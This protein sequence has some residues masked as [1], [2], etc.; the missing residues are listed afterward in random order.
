MSLSIGDRLGHD[1]VRTLIG[2]GGRPAARGEGPAATLSSARRLVAASMVLLCWTPSASLAQELAPGARYDPAIP[3][4]EATVGHDHGDEITTPEQVAR[5]LDALAAAAPNRLTVVEYARSWEGRPLYL[6]VIASSERIARLDELTADLR[7][8]SDPGALAAD[9]VERLVATLPVVTWLLHGVHGNEISSTDAALA[10]LYHLLASRDDETVDTILRESVVLIDPMQNPDGRARFIYQHLLGR[11][12]TPDPEPV[13]A[14][15]DE[16]WPGGRTNHYLF[17]MNRDWFGQT[18]PETRGRVG[19]YLEWFA[20]VVVDL[21]EMGGNSTYFFAP[22]T[23]PLNP[24]LSPSQGDWLDQ[25]GRQNAARFDSRGFPY[26]V[27]ESYDLF[28]PGYGDSWPSLHGAIGMTYEQAS[29]RGLVFRRTDDMQLSYRDGVVHH[30]TAALATAE[31]AA[32]NREALLRD[33]VA[34][35]RGSQDDEVVEYLLPP[36]NDV[37]RSDQLARVLTAQGIQVR[38]TLAPIDIDD[39]QLPAGTYIVPLAQGAGRLART[40]LDPVTAMDD[41]FVEEQDRRRRRRQ[42]DQIYDITGWSLPLVYDVEAIASDRVTEVETESVA[43]AWLGPQDARV[44]NRER[45]RTPVAPLA[46]AT[47]A[48]LMPW[49]LATAATVTEALAAGLRV[50]F[51]NKAFTLGGR[52]FPPG[53]AIVR[54]AEHGATLA[55]TLGGIVARHGAEVVGTDTGWVEDGISLGSNQVVALKTPRV[56]L[57]WDEPTSSQSAGW[58]R[59]VLERR[60]GQAVSAVRTD[61]FGRVRAG[62]LRCHRVALW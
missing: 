15:H 4:L 19:I 59:Y 60:Y 21:H 46:P 49:G 40:L 13:S 2:Q 26:F 43:P 37:G 39:R 1:E 5:Y 31:T 41:A 29:A 16:P 45:A 33:F 35:R 12:A 8:L 30:F 36:A 50:R 11:A 28:Y 34:H 62:P 23:R 38:R 9:E 42:S 7:R 57:A 55:S 10:E 17:D 6:C 24:N 27:R 47:V 51:A 53:T 32:R 52:V 58:T 25:F 20:H 14:E 48:Y 18:Q 3:T 56:L 54:V 44:T 61:A 22:P